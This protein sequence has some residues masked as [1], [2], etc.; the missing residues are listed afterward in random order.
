MENTQWSDK[1]PEVNHSIVLN[2]KKIKYLHNKKLSEEIS[3]TSDEHKMEELTK[4]AI[5][6][7]NQMEEK[8]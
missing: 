8:Q 3:T 2:I 6:L 4:E 1:F 7:S 5:K